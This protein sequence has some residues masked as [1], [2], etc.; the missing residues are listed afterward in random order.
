[1]KKKT[2]PLTVEERMAMDK[3]VDFY[4]YVGK[5][6]EDA[7]RLAWADI[8]KQFPHLKDYDASESE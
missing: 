7:G 2:T 1:M 5:S 6:E 8:Q 3:A 4:R